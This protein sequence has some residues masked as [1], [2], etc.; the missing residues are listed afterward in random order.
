MHNSLLMF[1]YLFTLSFIFF[2]QFTIFGQISLDYYLDKN[3]QYDESIPTPEQVLGYQVGQ[4]HI[5]H[6]Q[7]VYYMRTLAEKSN[8]IH[9]ETRGKTYEDRP[10]IL[11]TITSEKNH[12]NLE[13][14]R[15][16]H[17]TLTTKQGSDLDVDNMPV[18]VYQ[19]F[20]IHGNESSGANASVLAAY[21]L[22]ASQ[23]QKTKNLLD[24]TIIL[25]DPCL[26]PDGLQR[27]STWVNAHKSIHLNPDPND[28]EFDEPWPK[29]RTNHYWFDLNRDW[30]LLQ[31]PESRARVKT[32][33]KWYP[34]IVTDHHE[35]GTNSTF[36]FQPGVQSRVNPMTPKKNQDLTFKIAQ[37]HVQ[38][39]DSIGSLYYSKENF[40][41][42]YY[43]KG[44]TYPDVNGGI[45]ILFEQGSSRGHAQ[46]SQHGVLTFPFTIRNQLTTALST[47]DAAYHLRIDLLRYLQ[48]FYR[49]SFQ[50]SKSQKSNG[51]IF[52]SD[53]DPVRSFKLA[54]V[55]KQHD[56]DLYLLS[57]NIKKGDNHFD[58][59]SSYFI[60][61]EQKKHRLIR[62]IFEMQTEF[63]DSIFY[64]VSAWNF[65]LA[66]NLDYSLQNNTSLMGEKVGELELPK[67]SV[68]AKSD[69][70]YLVSPH[71]YYLPKL[72]RLLHQSEIRFLVGSKQFQID[73][74][75][76][77]YGTLL[78]P[79]VNQKINKDILY[80]SLIK[81][82]HKTMLQIDGVPTGFGPKIDLGSNN[83]STVKKPKIAM[84]VGRGIRS[85]DPG[86]I[87]HLM[88]YRFQTP[89]SK[90]DTR[91]FNQIDISEYSHLIIPSTSGDELDD[92]KDKIESFVASGG[93][94]IG[95][96]NTIN[97]LIG[98]DLLNVDVL[99]DDVT[100][101]KI[102]FEERYDFLG[103]QRIGGA[104]FNTKL[105][106]SHPINFGYSRD[107]LPIFRNSTLFLKADKNSYNNPI[108]YTSDP[109]LSGYISQRNLK[110]LKNSVPLKIE[111]KGRG[112][113]IVF[114]DNTNFRAFWLGTNRLLTNAI[115]FSDLM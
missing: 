14:I 26:N 18:V 5:S 19:G 3:H 86:E 78:I 87:W 59:S 16:K 61:F 80:D 72:I 42:F 83:F 105:D 63:E 29:G 46:N 94:L 22:A 32:L 115:Y 7:L 110:L 6:D 9:I 58:K 90:I 71:G 62:S 93:T 79:V 82:A 60:P 15:Q 38:A 10:V 47:L 103:A 53:K 37:Y 77:D 54:K 2:S 88:D 44:S 36:F 11:L 69:Y 97:W 99:K 68:T 8:R 50:M 113:I 35:M 43:G 41:D 100:A 57:Q 112:K 65:P 48:D 25:F 76:Y 104:I 95:Y 21:H 66:Y 45:G 114:T 13:N 107:F 39:L 17:H 27:F 81:F 74:K 24:N 98:K 34:N 52:G 108:Q 40:D 64:D 56:V 70:A 49:D 1:R 84:V 101:E 51:V 55:L 33:T 85:Y 20:S 28:R 89:I 31:H 67:G 75:S 111:K 12:Q 30:L 73:D 109:L 96:R 23:S 106:R 91:Y 92:A 4:W 102:S